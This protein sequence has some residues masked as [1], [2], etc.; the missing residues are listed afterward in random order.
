MEAKPEY[1]TTPTLPVTPEVRV[2]SSL[3]QWEQRILQAARVIRSRG[4]RGTMLV[5]WDGQVQT[6]SVVKPVDEHRG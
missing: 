6:I 5:T 4:K 3:P 1:V 2:V